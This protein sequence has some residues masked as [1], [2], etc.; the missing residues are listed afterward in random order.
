[1]CTVVNIDLIEVSDL[2]GN[3]FT[4]AEFSSETLEISAGETQEV[5]VT[6]TYVGD[7]PAV[8]VGGIDL[9][10]V[11]DGVEAGDFPGDTVFTVVASWEIDGEVVE[12]VFALPV[13]GSVVAGPQ[14]LP[15]GTVVSFDE[16]DVPDLDGYTFTGAAF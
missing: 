16:I 1:M 12:E 11:L 15:V 13:D 4:G 8:E 2:D 9:V 7:D 3:T 14:D 6:N 5:T 10:K